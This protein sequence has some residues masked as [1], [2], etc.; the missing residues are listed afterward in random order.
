MDPRYVPKSVDVSNSDQQL[1]IVWKDGE[2]SNFP[3]FGLRKNCPCVSCRGGHDKMG[4]FEPELFRVDPPRSYKIVKAQ[5][6]GNHALKIT[7]DDGHDAGMYRW[8]LLREMGTYTE[9]SLD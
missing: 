6:I 5:P 8:D 4:R 3:L 9:S 7:W 2:T 1:T